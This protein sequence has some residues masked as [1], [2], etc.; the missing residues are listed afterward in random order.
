M[1]SSLNIVQQFRPRLDQALATVIATGDP[2]DRY[3]IGEA[4]LTGVVY[5][6]LQRYAGIYLDELGA[7]DAAKRLAERTKDLLAHVRNKA[8]VSTEQG[9]DA[10]LFDAWEIIR[11]RGMSEALD[12]TVEN[13][14]ALEL[15][16]LGSGRLQARATVVE[17]TAV[18]RFSMSP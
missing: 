9:D 6:I 15:I 17:I 18:F 7:K 3:F 4:I 2:Q 5:F 16:E 11:A 14:L 13:A 8:S 10:V 12:R 1:Q